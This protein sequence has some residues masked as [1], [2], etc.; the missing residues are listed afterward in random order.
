MTIFTLYLGTLHI[1]T[2][3]GVSRPPVTVTGLTAVSRVTVTASLACHGSPVR[4]VTLLLV[5]VLGPVLAKDGLD[6]LLHE[7]PG[8]V[9]ALQGTL[10]PARAV[11]LQTG[12]QGAHSL[13]TDKSASGPSSTD[14][15]EH[16]PFFLDKTVS[17]RV[18]FHPTSLPCLMMESLQQEK[19]NL[20]VGLEGHCTKCVSSNLPRQL[21]HFSS[22]APSA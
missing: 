7:G 9:A 4:H 20:C 22:G 13:N 16:T 2:S 12:G 5:A 3:L 21:V 1:V 6:L 15:L 17:K 11:G 19:Q 18:A 10:V 14:I 8:H